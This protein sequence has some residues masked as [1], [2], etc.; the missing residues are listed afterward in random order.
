MKRK[1]ET[2][3]EHNLRNYILKQA[4]KRAFIELLGSVCSHCK[5]NLIDHP[6][7]AVFHHVDP[8]EK[9]FE[10]NI[11][12]TRN[13]QRSLHEIKKCILLCANCHNETHFDRN[14][15]QN[16][17]ENIISS[18]KKL[19]NIQPSGKGTKTNLDTK[20]VI[21]LYQ[22]IKSIGEVARILKISRGPIRD[23]LNQNQI[24]IMKIQRPPNRG[25][26]KI[27]KEKIVSL[28]DRGI[29]D[30][31]QMAKE[32]ECSPTTVLSLM[33][34]YKI[35]DIHY[36]ERYPKFSKESIQKLI[37]KNPKISISEIARKLKTTWSIA[38][39]CIQKHNISLQNLGS[40]IEI[41]TPQ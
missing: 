7:Y 4:R 15:F 32:L 41:I 9:Q 1:Y 24:P 36:K 37:D 38:K 28:L 23:I 33:R 20:E 2:Q 26:Y 34:V 29:W 8:K 10:P 17:L 25:K 13:F 27:T 21:N 40:P 31:K 11:L 5:T 14:R 12:V 18:S 19:V 22:K 3:E 35:E 30:R 39:S 16:V 6:S